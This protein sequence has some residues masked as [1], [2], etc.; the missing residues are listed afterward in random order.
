MNAVTDQQL[1]QD[2]L[3][4]STEAAFA[5][6][7]RR[8]VDLVYCVAHRITGNRHT[9]EDVTQATFVA[10]ARH[11]WQL[12][13]RFVLA[14]WLHRTA[15]NLAAKTIRTNVRRRAREQ[16]VALMNEGVSSCQNDCWEEI[17]PWLDWALAQ[18]NDSDRDV[19]VLRFFQRKSDQ[20]IGLSMGL[21]E[22]AAQRRV[23]RAVER[24]RKS[25]AKQGISVSGGILVAAVSANAIQAAPAGLAAAISTAGSLA[26]SATSSSP[27]QLIMTTL[28]AKHL[29]LT[30]IAVLL[31]LTA[32]LC[33]RN[34][35]LRN[36]LEQARLTELSASHAEDTTSGAAE[37]RI[38]AEDRQRFR[39]E[40]L[41]LL[42]L[43]GRVAQLSRELR[44]R[45]ARQVAPVDTPADQDSILFSASVTNRIPL[46]NTLAVGGW[47]QK[48]MRGYLL[49]TPEI[50]R[51]ETA[52]ESERLI[53]KSVVIAAPEAFWSQIGWGDAKSDLRRSTLSGLMNGEEVELLLQALKETK[54]AEISNQ[55]ISKGA[56]GER[57]GIGFSV[58]DDTESG[59]LMGVDV[60]P[61][62]SPGGQSV[63][64]EVQP[65]TLPADAPIHPSLSRSV[66]TNRSS[67][68]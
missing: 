23:S 61:R 4:R 3:E 31:V 28:K 22:A 37:P 1:I 36:Q 21:T 29:A 63:D 35:A 41:E 46:G 18:L 20:E 44:E 65:S 43:R 68:P 60:Q 57:L 54:G 30:L 24:L 12:R 2:Y 42:S 48:E 33:F 47:H 5:E 50:A 16:E 14:G 56:D 58:A 64:L 9:A 17:A 25:F 67:S 27:W 45:D 7:V 49:L 6:L 13:D 19:V 34:I 62:I 55:S 40:H 53:V 11:A 26:V 39:K 38:T 59:A 51:G 32:Y 66:M 52:S 8:Y 15:R 10:L